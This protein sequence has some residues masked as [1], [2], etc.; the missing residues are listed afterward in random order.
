MPAFFVNGSFLHITGNIIHLSAL[1]CQKGTAM[2]KYDK[3][4]KKSL[5][6]WLIIS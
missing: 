5:K 3:A 1:C 2:D 6:N 4:C